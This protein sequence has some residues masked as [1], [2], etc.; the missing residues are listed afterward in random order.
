[1]LPLIVKRDPACCVTL[2]VCLVECVGLWLG[3]AVLGVVLVDT[4]NGI[5]SRY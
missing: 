1:M 4:V 2:T 3:V 5:S